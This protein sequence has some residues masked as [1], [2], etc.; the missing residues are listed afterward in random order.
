MIIRDI[1]GHALAVTDH[2]ENVEILINFSDDSRSV[3]LTPDQAEA[4]GR[5][6]RNLAADQRMGVTA[7]CREWASKGHHRP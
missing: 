5:V 3:I 1:D 4:L 2:D 6:L 7:Y